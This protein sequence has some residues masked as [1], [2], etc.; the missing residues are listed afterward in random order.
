MFRIWT[1]PPLVALWW[2]VEG[3]TNPVCELDVRPGGR[4]RI[5]MQ[6]ASGRIYRNEGVYLDVVE[7]ERL[8]YSD[9]PDPELPE[10][11]GETPGARRHT[12]PIV[13]RGGRTEVTLEVAMESEADH[14]RM[15]AFGMPNGL[16]QG[17]ERLSDLLAALRSERTNAGRP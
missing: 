5:D 11:Q 8:V 16:A 10:W 3:A 13:P 1:H 2:G 12:V 7:N 17:M 6:T 9:I 15:T 4:W 14:A